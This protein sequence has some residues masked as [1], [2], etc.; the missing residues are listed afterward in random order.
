MA[1][2]PRNKKNSQKDFII[3]R[4]SRLFRSKGFKAASM[5]ELAEALGVE[6]PSL[7][8]HI[9]SKDELL[10]DIC[11]K[12]AETFTFNLNIICKTES[13]T[14]NKIESVIRFHIKMMA[15]NFDEVFVANHDWKYLLE[16]FLTDFLSRRR[17]YE[18][19]LIMLVEKGIHQKE[20]KTGNAYIIVLTIL[21]A[22]RGLEFWQRHKKNI[23]AKILEDT[24]VNQLL[25]GIIK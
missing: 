14:V 24:M 19:E 1:K 3:K 21:S 13:K 15:E 25:H 20:L 9:T 17:N 2:I 5:R 16:P 10:Q 18:K 6:A 12:V 8:N 22:V 4:A 23:S 11:F 7:Y